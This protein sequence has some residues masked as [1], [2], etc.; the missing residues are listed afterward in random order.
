[1]AYE[2]TVQDSNTIIIAD[3]LVNEYQSRPVATE[4]DE[5]ISI[6]ETTVHCEPGLS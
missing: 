1:M 5:S 4:I 2:S 6:N 3:N